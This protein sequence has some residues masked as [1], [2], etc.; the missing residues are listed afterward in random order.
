MDTKKK[1]MNETASTL[2]VG[3]WMGPITSVNNVATDVSLQGKNLK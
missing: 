1:L 3:G 2:S